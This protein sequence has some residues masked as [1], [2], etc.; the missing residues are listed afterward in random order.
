MNEQSWSEVLE[1]MRCKDAAE[2]FV[3]ELREVGARITMLDGEP[4]RTA[5]LDHVSVAIDTY[6]VD[7][8]VT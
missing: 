3:L 5:K 2:R 7:S 6:S 4:L 8:R 1:D